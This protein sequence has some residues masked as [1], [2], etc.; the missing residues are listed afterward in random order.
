M[1]IFTSLYM[2]KKYCTN[3]WFPGSHNSIR[4]HD[5]L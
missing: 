2:Y 4:N 3:V 1:Y 5:E